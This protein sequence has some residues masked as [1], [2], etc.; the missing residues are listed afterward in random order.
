[1]ISNEERLA[2]WNLKKILY[3]VESLEPPEQFSPDSSY[4]MGEMKSTNGKKTKH[5]Q[6]LKDYFSNEES[7]GALVFD[8]EKGEVRQIPE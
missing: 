3:G 4:N 6:S 2:S 5:D 7:P 1:M 8:F